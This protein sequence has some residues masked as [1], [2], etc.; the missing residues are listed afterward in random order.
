MATALIT[1]ASSGLGLEFAKLHARDGHSLILVARRK[2][3]LEEI[4]GRLRTENPK[5]RVD[6]IDLDLGA[7][8]AGQGLFDRVNQ[9]GRTV[10]YLVN[11]AGF[12]SNGEFAKQPLAKEIQMIDLNIRTLVEATHLFLG[13]MVARGSGKILNIGSTAGFQPGPFMATYYATKA[14]V[15]S[16]SEALHEE[17]RGTGVTCTVLAPGATATEFAQ[18]AN[19]SSSRLFN[20]GLV[21][22]SRDV[23]RIGYRAM[24]AGRPLAVAG[25]VNRWMVQALRVT[26]RFVVRRMVAAMNQG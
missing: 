1:G 13:P 4:A 22:N 20:T 25:L 16:F 21:A 2:D 14:F 23:A 7:P 24:L 11:N 19:S 18:S 5:I 17:L 15:N 10:D 9:M 8:G 12:G 3:M 26:P 6:V